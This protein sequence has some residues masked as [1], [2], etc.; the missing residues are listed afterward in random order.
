MFLV[1]VSSPLPLIRSYRIE[2]YFSVP[3]VSYVARTP[4]APPTLL[5]GKLGGLPPGPAAL[6]PRT[7][8]ATAYGTAGTDTVFTETVT[9]TVTE[10]ATETAAETDT[11]TAT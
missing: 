10:T 8:P 1:S 4:K 11:G 5:R 7:R 3:A 9:E 2:F 6:L